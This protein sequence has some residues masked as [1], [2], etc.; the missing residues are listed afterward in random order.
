[1]KAVIVEIFI[2]DSLGLETRKISELSYCLQ[3]CL[4]VILPKLRNFVYT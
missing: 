2:I 3:V 4:C 1:M